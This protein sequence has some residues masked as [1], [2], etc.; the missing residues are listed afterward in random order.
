M[1]QQRNSGAKVGWCI[2]WTTLYRIVKTGVSDEM[3]LELI[4][5]GRARWNPRGMWGKSLRRRRNSKSEGPGVGTCLMFL[6]AVEKPV[7]FEQI[8]PRG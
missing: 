1:Q 6:E 8:T 3:T 5:E 7:C 4:A 2:V